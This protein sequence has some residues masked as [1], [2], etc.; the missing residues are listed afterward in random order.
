MTTEIEKQ[1]FEGFRIAPT[2]IQV[3]TPKSV[4][5]GIDENYIRNEYPLITPEIVLKLQEIVRN[6]ADRIEIVIDKDEYEYILTKGERLLCN[7]HCEYDYDKRIFVYG[8]E[9]KETLLKL[10]IQLKDELQNEVIDLMAC[11]S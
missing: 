10:L 3:T 4:Y 5:Y 6:Y 8:K 2:K 9:Y 7:C 11:T 1:F